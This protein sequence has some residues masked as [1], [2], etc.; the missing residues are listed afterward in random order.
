MTPRVVCLVICAGSIVGT[1]LVSVLTREYSWV[2]RVWSI[3]PTVY[4]WVFAAAAEFDA[5]LVLMASLVTLRG[6]RLTFNAG[7]RGRSECSSGPSSGGRRRTG[8][9]LL[10]LLFIGSTAFTESISRSK[11]PGYD[12]YRARTSALVPWF[13]RG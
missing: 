5:R 13:P 7:S 3:A 11:Y 8:A 6:I 9:M 1:W 10:T 2:D 12:E 4:V